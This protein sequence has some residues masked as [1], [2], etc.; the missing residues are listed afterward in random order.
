LKLRMFFFIFKTRWKTAGTNANIMPLSFGSVDGQ[1]F[2][3]M[4]LKRTFNA[5]SNDLTT[6]YEGEWLGGE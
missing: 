3:I 4:S 5:E 2:R 1:D 6:D